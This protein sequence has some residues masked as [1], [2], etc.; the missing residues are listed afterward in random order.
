M[1]KALFGHVGG[2]PTLCSWPRSV[3]CV[4]EYVSSS[5]SSIVRWAIN[6]LL[7]SRID[8]SD[9]LLAL[10]GSPR[11]PD[12]SSPRPHGTAPLCCSE[13]ALPGRAS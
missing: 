4:P 3:G 2:T 11:S 12:P 8:V 5:P 7:A 10:E 9:E 6:E 1:A 13:D